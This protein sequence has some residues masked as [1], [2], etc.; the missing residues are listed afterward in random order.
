MKVSNMT[1]NK[2]NKIANQ[3]IVSDNQVSFFQSY[4]SVIARKDLTTNEITLDEHYWDYS[5]T[6]SKYRNI[7]LAMTTKEILKAIKENTIKFDSL[8]DMEGTSKSRF[9][10]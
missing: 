4:N 7:F 2:G 3:F 8:N 9:I 10:A 1:S 6:T 5:R